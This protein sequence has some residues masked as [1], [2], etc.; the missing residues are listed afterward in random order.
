MPIRFLRLTLLASSSASSTYY[1]IRLRRLVLAASLSFESKKAFKY[2][3]ARFAATHGGTL[4]PLLPSG[5]DGVH[6]PPLHGTRPYFSKKDSQKL[7]I[8]K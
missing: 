5:P 4:L 7:L 3:V 6:K 8:D 1:L 2:L